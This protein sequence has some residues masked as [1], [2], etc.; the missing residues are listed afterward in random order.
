M[1]SAENRSD[2]TLVRITPLQSKDCLRRFACGQAEID[3]WAT[4]TAHRLHLKNRARVQCARTPNR[5]SGPAL[6]FYSL[7]FTME[8]NSKVIK[9]DRDAWANGAPLIFIHYLAVQRERQK[10]GVGTQL[11][12]H[13][14]KSSF[15]ISKIIPPYGVALRS[16]NEQTTE[17]YQKFGFSLAPDESENHNPLMILPIWTI[18][19]LFEGRD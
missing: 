18:S 1:T 13:A 19:D 6:G 5:E 14:L 4:V 16:L 7:N 11:L 10:N 2:Q 8:D 15:E 9:S 17:F 12:L 3:R